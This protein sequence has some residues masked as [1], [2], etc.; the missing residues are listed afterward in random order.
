MPKCVMV[1]VRQAVALAEFGK[2]ACYAVRVH[3]LSIFLRKQ[4]SLIVIILP[5]PQP[6]RV[7]PCPVLPKELH[8]FRW[9]RNPTI[10]G[11]SFRSRFVP[12]AESRAA[13][14]MFRRFSRLALFLRPKVKIIVE[15]L[16][17]ICH[18]GRNTNRKKAAFYYETYL[19]RHP[20]PRRLWKNDP[21][22]GAFICL[23]RAA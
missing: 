12:R 17:Q 14:C 2:P 4:E 20:C 15:P 16:G 18:N 13:F 22:R 19:H 6:F 10:R 9:Q 8:R 5:Q 1:D 23:R 3:R 7:L 11:C 21:L